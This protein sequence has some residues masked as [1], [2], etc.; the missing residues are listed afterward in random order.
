MKVTTVPKFHVMR[1]T[2]AVHHV[3]LNEVRKKA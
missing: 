3:K 2:G 1:I